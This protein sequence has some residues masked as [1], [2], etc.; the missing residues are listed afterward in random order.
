MKI[1]LLG[2][3]VGLAINFAVPTFAQEK[4]TVDPQTAQQI[5]ALSIKY[6]EAFNNNDAAALAAL[7]ME[8]AVEVTDTGPIYGREAI[9]KHFADVFKQVH[10][11]NHL[12]E[13]DQYS[14]HIIG[15]GNE[16]WAN[17]EWSLTF[18]G[19]SGGPIQAKGYW[20]AIDTREGDTWKIR[21]LTWNVTPPPPAPAQTK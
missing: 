1:R 19:K 7:Y 2:A 4:E 12:G 15:P 8:D 18:Q 11:T 13:G 5:R 17:G 9:E 20:S 10:V 21:M 14:P 6:D 3:L 16:I